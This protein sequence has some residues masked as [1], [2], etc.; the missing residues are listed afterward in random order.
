VSVPVEFP[1]MIRIVPGS[2]STLRYR[3]VA[4]VELYT[5]LLFLDLGLPLA[6]DKSPNGG[7]FKDITVAEGAGSY[8]V[9]GSTGGFSDF[10]IVLDLRAINNVINLK[11]NDLQAALNAYSGSMPPAVASTLQTLLSQA[12]SAYQAGNLPEAIT[13]IAAFSAYVLAHSGTDIPDVWY[14]N[15]PS[16]VNVAGILRSGADS[17]KFSLQ[18]KAGS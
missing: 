10:L 17:V 6:L 1:V 3:G 12:R 9:G 2:G 15:N 13:K 16:V 11:F 8:R 5:H 4:K 18:R 14:A 7:F